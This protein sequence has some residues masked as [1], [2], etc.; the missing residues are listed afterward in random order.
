MSSEEAKAFHSIT[1]GEKNTWDDWHLVPVSRPLV[2]PPQVR[3]HLVE[4]PYS[5]NVIDMT[6]IS[7]GRSTYANRTGSWEFYVI[8]SGQIVENSSYG[9]WYNRY[10]SIMQYLH[11]KEF[12]AV[13]D[14]DP[15]YCYIGRFSVDGWHSGSGNSTITISYNVKPYKYVIAP[16]NGMW[17]WD[18]LCF[19]YPELPQND[20]SNRGDYI[21]NYKNIKVTDRL[22]VHYR[23]SADVTS[24]PIIKTSAKGMTVT[25][26]DTTY[27]LKK[28]ENVMS[29]IHFVSGDNI[30]T[31]RGNG[32]VTIEATGGIL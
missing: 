18:T 29:H 31:F 6:E 7:I 26:D 4:I 17:I 27:S 2:E 16:S 23:T 25:F 22:V 20:P 13:L 5:N 24:T 32:R 3:T 15:N 21:P 19:K 12:Q 10:T 11:G 14:D 30:L 9:K 28:G 8:N 1:I